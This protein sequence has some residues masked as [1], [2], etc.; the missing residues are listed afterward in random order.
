MALLLFAL[1]IVLPI[2]EL[3]VIIKVGVAIGVIPTLALLIL[4]SVA[5]TMLVKQQGLATWRRLQEALQRGETPT[6]EV[7]DGALILLGGA[8]LLTP[9]F[10]SDIMG[11][12]LLFPPTRAVLKGT[13][14]RWLGFLALGRLGAVGKAGQVGRRVYEARADRYR[15]A[16]T[17]PETPEAQLPR[18]PYPDVEGDSPDRG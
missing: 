18:G 2:V 4:V 13:F 3:W 5:G 10:V 11:L 1:F 9:G 17:T 12:F 15:P 14:R 6:K 8:L 16:P 7:T